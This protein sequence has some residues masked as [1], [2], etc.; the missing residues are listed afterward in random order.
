MVDIDYRALVSQADLVYESPAEW[1]V[2]GTPI[3]N[4]RRGTMAWTTPSAVHFQINRCDVFASDRYHAGHQYGDCDYAGACAQVTLDVGDDVFHTG[5]GFRQHLSVYD[6]EFT[7]AAADIYVRGFV[8]S[9]DDVMVLQVDDQRPDPQ[10]LRLTVSMWRPPQVETVLTLWPDKTLKTGTHVAR[11]TFEEGAHSI[12]LRQAFDEIREFTDSSYHGTSAVA[13][14]VADR[15]VTID[16]DSDRSRTLAT[17]AMNGKATFH[18]A[19]AASETI[20]LPETIADSSYDALRRVHTE[21]WHDFWARTFVHL[22]SADGVAEFM[23]HMRTL[24]LYYLASSSRGEFPPNGIGLLFQTGG[25]VH[26]AGAQFWVWIQEMAIYPAFAADAMDLAEPYFNMHIRQLPDCI[27]AARQRWGVD[28]GAFFSETTAFDGP[29]VLPAESAQEV[30]EL[31][32]GKAA[33]DSLSP[34]T[35]ARCAYESQLFYMSNHKDDGETSRRA[36]APIGHVVSSASE[37]AIA[38]WWCYRCTGDTTWLAGTAYPLLRET[39]EFYRHFVVKDDDGRYHLHGINVHEQFYLVKDSLVDLAA[40][41]GTAPLAIRAA[42]ILGVDTGLRDQWQE[43]LDNLAPHPMGHE[44]ASQ[45][46]TLSVLADDVWA[47]GHLGDVDLRPA[48]H[49]SEDVWLFPVFPFENWTLESRD[50]VDGRIVQKLIDLVPNHK[51]VMETGDWRPSLIRT[52]ISCA[53]AGRGE[54]L[55]AILA[56]HLAAYTPLLAN[57]LS[58]FETG[59]QSMG[60]E[61]SGLLATVMQEGLLQSV[62]P[63][64]GEPEI[65][66]V[67]PAWPK[68]WQATFRLLARGGFL[69]T[70]A[71]RDGEVDFVELESRLGEACRIRNP[72]QQPCFLTEVDGATREL[73]G[74]VLR[75]ATCPGQ[76]YRLQRQRDHQPGD[77]RIA[78]G[79]VAG[80]VSMSFTLSSGVTVG[81]SIGRHRDEP[82]KGLQAREEQKAAHE[83]GRWG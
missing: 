7:V 21:W 34:E 27:E 13:A 61:H 41:R 47:A 48:G 22:G 81:G 73:D 56:S 67:C 62:S 68:A 69:V 26:H 74:D 3:G 38:A 19:S 24:H 78:P 29:V 18:I 25:D 76:S 1:S 4:G 9:A 44:P 10:P 75:F 70:A 83:Y 82:D 80:P 55:P 28:G 6:A 17:S 16:T 54:E 52:P 35:R 32:L 79:P 57:G 77:R 15:P 72:W 2:E 60:I 58:L 51:F 39:A 11:Y 45:A 40:I 31:L 59:V 42:E 53:R 49:G 33:A 30:Q 63:R 37:I 5:N 14:A 23:A 66:S 71:V 36:F 50:P 65:I 20:D 43:L 64:P 8:H 12:V 46:L